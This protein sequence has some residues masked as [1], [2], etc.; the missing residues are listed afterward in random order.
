MWKKNFI[1]LAIFGLLT[2]VLSGN[3]YANSNNLASQTQLVPVETSIDTNIDVQNK[4]KVKINTELFNIAPKIESIINENPSIFGG[5][6]MY[7]DHLVVQ[8][9]NNPDSI[10]YINEKISSNKIKYEKVNTSKEMLD[11]TKSKVLGLLSNKEVPG[12]IGAGIDVKK[13]K[14]SVYVNDFSV[15]KDLATYFNDNV[16]EYNKLSY[17]EDQVKPGDKILTS[18]SSTCT[19][20][21]NAVVN[22]NNVTVT[23]G[24]CSNAP[25]GTGAW[26]VGSTTIGN[27]TSRSS[28]NTTGDA[29]Y[30]TLNSSSYIEV[31]EKKTGIGIGRGDDNGQYDIVG[32]QVAISAPSSTY[33]IF[34]NVVQKDVTIDFD[35]INGYNSIS[36][37]RFTD[38]TLTQAG[39]SGAPVLQQRYN[40]SKDRF[41]FVVEGVHKGAITV[42]PQGGSPT[43]YE[44]YSSFAGVQNAIGATALYVQS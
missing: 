40:T 11:E 26:K 6:Y 27:W 31:F 8:V 34:S 3:A 21:Y 24:H 43:T 32:A 12:L 15:I 23:A 33:L 30:I 28:G 16:I 39:D 7:E 29:G 18:S 14:V 4:E 2:L 41:D 1:K 35:G 38:T 37:L 19:A 36:G 42:T 25:G 44:V 5:Y 17:I 9:L 13:N 10:S 20:A 22:G